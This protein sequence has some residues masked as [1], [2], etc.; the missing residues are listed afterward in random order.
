MELSFFLMNPL[1]P[2]RSWCEAIEF[3][4][5]ILLVAF[6][7]V[8]V[9]ISNTSK[10]DNSLLTDALDFEF[11]Y[12]V[13]TSTLLA[14]ISD[15]VFPEVHIFE[16]KVFLVRFFELLHGWLELI[17]EL[18]EDVLAES[19]TQRGEFLEKTAVEDN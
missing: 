4:H 15:L 5:R 7:C 8:L 13:N 9:A 17:L 14:A 12:L 2:W 1:P 11:N 19:L 3:E 16:L 6:H 10:V 18:E